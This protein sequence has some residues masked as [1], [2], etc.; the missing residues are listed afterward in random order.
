MR[1]IAVLVLLAG[2]ARADEPPLDPERVV[3]EVV[4]TPALALGVALAGGAVGA[5]YGFDVWLY[6]HR[7]GNAVEDGAYVGAIAGY[8]IAVPAFAYLISQA[9]DSEGSAVGAFVGATLGAL[10]GLYL[11]RDEKWRDWPVLL[12]GPVVGAVLGCNLRRHYYV[13]QPLVAPKTVGVAW[14]ATF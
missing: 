13:P 2:V 7:E 14:S 11:M 6:H 3:G 9:K 4:G 5:W 10:P 1:A 8:L 12:V